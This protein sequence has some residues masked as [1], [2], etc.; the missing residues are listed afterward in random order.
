MGAV[1][2]GG[3]RLVG[4]D[5]L[6]LG[7]GSVGDVGLGDCDRLGLGDVDSRGVGNLSDNRLGLNP[8]VRFDDWLF[9]ADLI[10][11]E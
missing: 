9:G 3:V 11:N 4:S 2:S 8:G 5:S 1:A 6:V 7:S 10:K